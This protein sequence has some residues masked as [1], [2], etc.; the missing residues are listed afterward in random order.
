MDKGNEIKRPNP[1]DSKKT[2]L[3]VGVVLLLFLGLTVLEITLQGK[4]GPSLLPTNVVIFAL[5][6]LNILLLLIFMLLLGR[7]LIKLYFERRRGVIGSRFKTKLVLAFIG[8]SI[9]PTLM[10]FMVASGI[11]TSLVDSWFSVQQDLFMKESLSIAQEYLE[12]WN[13]DAKRLF[14]ALDNC[15]GLRM[16]SPFLTSDRLNRAAKEHG[17]KL[18]EVFDSQGRLMAQSK[19]K[20]R[21]STEEKLVREHLR[22][23]DRISGEEEEKT[24]KVFVKG[25]DRIMVVTY[26]IPSSV[27]KSLTTISNIYKG[28]QEMKSVSK[29]VKWLYIISFMVV[30]M[31]ILFSSMWIGLQIAKG[32]TVPIEAL[33]NATQEVAAGDLDVSVGVKADDEIGILVN[34]FNSM[35]QELKKNRRRLEEGKRYIETVLESVAT[36]VISLDKEGK[37]ISINAAARHLLGLEETAQFEGR[38]YRFLL[39]EGPFQALSDTIRDALR[40]SDQTGRNEVR[41]VRESGVL[42]L[43]VGVTPIY[44]QNGR[45]DGMVIVLEDMTDLAK[46]QRASAWEEVARRVAHEIKN[47]LTPIKLS[48]QRIERR[49]KHTELPEDEKSVIQHCLYTITN[50]VDLMKNMVNEFHQFARFPKITPVPCRIE[51][52]VDEI[53]TTY[54]SSHPKIEISVE[55]LGE[56]PQVMLDKEQMKRVLMNLVDNAIEAMK[57]KGR[58]EIR[59]LKDDTNNQFVIEVKDEGE[60]IPAEDRELIFQPYFTTKQ[61]GTGLGLAIVNRIVT[62]HGGYIR[63]RPNRPKGSVFVIELPITEV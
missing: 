22:S 52:I 60:G 57:G 19:H 54:H 28:Y 27:R 24:Y 42:I 43:N 18:I 14:T 58:I 30:T 63:V 7:N 13:S 29:S 16:E 11:I 12:R 51:E 3:L 55:A 41:L 31:L 50:Q 15:T 9:I 5:I 47:P 44:D 4:K 37:I 35:T 40:Q 34:S 48:A 1:T 62:D 6:N 23:N 56:L 20:P 10:L 21:Y 53:R 61:G 45:Y 25:K 46:A 2:I 33:A 49:L 32:I 17:A 39:S 8:L 38:S 36:G 26:K 59:L